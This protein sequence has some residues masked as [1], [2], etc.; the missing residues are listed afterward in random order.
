MRTLIIS[1]LFLTIGNFVYS[2]SIE[3]D[4]PEFAGNIVYVNDTIGQGKKLEQQT[5]SSKASANAASYIPGARLFA[6]KSTYKSVVNGCCSPVVIDHKTNIRFI[7][8]MVDNSYDPTTIINIFELKREKNKRTVELA[9]SNTW[10]TTKSGDIEFVAFNGTK[11]GGSSYL[12]EI[13]YIESGEYAITLSD[14]RDFFN[15]FQISE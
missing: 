6:G 10:G 7:V 15:L 9:S 8:K 11:Y 4:E 14:R 3:I 12:I 13:P 2:Q 5:A 1:I